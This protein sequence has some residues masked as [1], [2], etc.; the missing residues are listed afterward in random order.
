[1]KKYLIRYIAFPLALLVASQTIA[2]A[3]QFSGQPLTI[4]VNYPPGGPADIDARII[5]RH[6][7]RFLNGVSTVVI[8]NVGGAGGRIGVNLLGKSVDRDRLTLGVFTWNP[9]D[10]IIQ[11]VTLQVRYQDLRFVAGYQ[12]PTVV[13]VRKDSGA[14][15]K[16]GADLIKSGKFIAGALSPNSHSTIRMCLALDLLNAKYH[17]VAGYKGLFETELALRQNAIQLTNTS[18]SS[19]ASSV[20]PSLIDSGIAMAAFQYDTIRSDGSLG[21]S[22]ELLDIPSF[23]EVFQAVHGN[24]AMPQGEKWQ[25]LKTLNR[26]MDSMYRTVFLPPTAP[27]AAILE[28][29]EAFEKMGKDP[30]Y[31]ADYEKV[32]RAKPRILLGEEGDR[33]IADLGTMPSATAAFIKDYISILGR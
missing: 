33:I 8:R 26:L 9:I 25:L 23:L 3:Q 6:I 14:L 27:K 32:V 4:L 20:R 16:D 18:L 24:G 5:A 19:W 31:I 22:P 1:V 29:R 7:P 12:Q 17:L 30:S 11:E 28:M 15:G 2:I 21:R 13:Y 10:Q